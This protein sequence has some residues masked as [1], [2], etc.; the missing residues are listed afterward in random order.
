MYAYLFGTYNFNR[1]PLAPPGTQVVVHA[2]PSDRASWGFHGRDGWT[3]GSSLEHYRCIKSY[4]PATKS[5]INCDTLAFFPHDI[6]IPKVSTEDYLKQATQDII[7]L[8]THPVA[9]LPSLQVGDVTKN[10]LLDIAQIIKRSITNIVP[11]NSRN[12]KYQTPLP[13]NIRRQI[14]PLPRNVSNNIPELI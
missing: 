6:P 8:L 4:I 7:T 14:N 12:E 3:I 5:E 9:S 11:L 13:A 2:K 10:A 1:Y